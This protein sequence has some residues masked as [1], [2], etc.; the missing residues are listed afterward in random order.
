MVAIFEH[1][2]MP[3][4]CLSPILCLSVAQHVVHVIN[5][6]CVCKALQF[7]YRANGCLKI[8]LGVKLHINDYQNLIDIRLS[9]CTFIL[10]CLTTISSFFLNNYV[11][12]KKPPPQNPWLVY[13]AAYNFISLWVYSQMCQN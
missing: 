7:N 9:F 13:I 4:F 5:I 6:H 8:Y 10:L 1:R 11:D 2:N 3:L 12:G